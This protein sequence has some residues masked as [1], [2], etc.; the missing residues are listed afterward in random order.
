MHHTDHHCMIIRDL[1]HAF[2][3]LNDAVIL[4]SLP[5][6]EASMN[7]GIRSKPLTLL[8]VIICNLFG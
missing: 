4:A 6:N 3:P 2:P 1:N 5:E 8:P 7:T